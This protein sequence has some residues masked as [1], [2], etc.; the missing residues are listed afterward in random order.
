M[1]QSIKNIWLLNA[2]IVLDYGRFGQC[3][4]PALFARK[5]Q[6]LE[7]RWTCFRSAPPS[8]VVAVAVADN[9]RSVVGC[10]QRRR[11]GLSACL[12]WLKKQPSDNAETVRFESLCVPRD[13]IK[14]CVF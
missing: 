7:P 4:N 14:S 6:T 10:S 5:R 3:K 9:S 13:S 1:K 2:I 12:F 11:V 8:T